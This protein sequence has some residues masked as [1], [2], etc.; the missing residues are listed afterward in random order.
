MPSEKFILAKRMRMRKKNKDALRTEGT[1]GYNQLF[2]CRW[3]LIDMVILSVLL[4]LDQFTKYLAIQ[5]L[6]DKPSVVLI[7]GV[8]EFQYLENTGSA[9]SLFQGKKMFLLIMGFVFL[10]AVL[11]FLYKVPAQKKFR[12]VHVLTAVLIAG[13]LGNMADRIRYDFVVDFISFVLIHFPVFNIAD[14]Y[15]VISAICMFLLFIFVYK[16]EDLEWIGFSSKNSFP[17][18]K[19]NDKEKP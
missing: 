7:K 17:E 3:Y 15:I 6:K 10:A 11:F 1:V 19:N 9:F 18:T 4:S 16:E 5:Y 13:A 12:A 14:C 8:L 2:R